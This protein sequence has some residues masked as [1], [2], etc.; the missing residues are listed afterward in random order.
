VVLITGLFGLLIGSFL[1]VVVWRLPRGESLSH[2]GSHCPVCD[3]PIRAYD[4]IPVVSWLLLRGR[5]RDCGTRISA[6]YPLVE[7]ATGLLFALTAWWVGL[8]VLLPFALWFMAAC[9]ALFLI[10]LEVH[11]LPNSLTLSTYGV[12]LV[13]FTLTAAVEDAWPSLLRAVLGG[14]AL[15]LVYA[16]LAGFFP[17]GMG[18]GD[19]KLALSLGSAMAWVGWGA[20]VVGGFGAFVLGAVWGMAAIVAGKA[21]RKSALPFGPFMIVAA[22]LSTVWGQR[23]ADWYT[24]SL[25]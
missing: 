11:R 25:I 19:A 6:R 21:G 24:D 18:W 15:A 22:L 23:I 7:L 2:P 1:N 17:R 4:N 13:G 9:I 10:D 16:L 5:C 12:V 8:S 14:L 20:L 3:H